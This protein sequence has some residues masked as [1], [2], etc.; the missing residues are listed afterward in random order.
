MNAVVVGTDIYS[1]A[2][3]RTVDCT[4]SA[5]FIVDYMVQIIGKT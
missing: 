4:Q 1:S 3:L 5:T 2:K